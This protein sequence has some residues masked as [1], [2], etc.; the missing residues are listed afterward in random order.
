MILHEILNIYYFSKYKF[1]ILQNVRKQNHIDDKI[2]ISSL[3]IA[4]EVL[5][6]LKA[7]NNKK[8]YKFQ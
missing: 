1:N 6:I 5:Q 4:K 8:T 7:C 2:F 3:Y